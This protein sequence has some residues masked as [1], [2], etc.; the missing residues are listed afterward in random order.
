MMTPYRSRA[1]KKNLQQGV[2]KMEQSLT[3]LQKSWRSIAAGRPAV[4]D[5]DD[6]L[7]VWQRSLEL[8]RK[9]KHAASEIQGE[10]TSAAI[11]FTTAD[12]PA[13]DPTAT[14]LLSEAAPH[15]ALGWL[16]SAKSTPHG[17]GMLFAAR[18]ANEKRSFAYP[19]DRTNEGSQMLGHA[20]KKQ[21][22]GRVRN[23]T[24]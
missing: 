20:L 11:V 14:V 8:L 12:M 21:R 7:A 6:A 9:F 18:D 10:V 17:I 23:S 4:M 13:A 15:E 16:L 3:P 1:A 5:L 22:S 24:N 2:E 19:F